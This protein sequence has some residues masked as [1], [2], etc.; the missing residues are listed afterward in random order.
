MATRKFSTLRG[1]RMRVTALDGCGRPIEGPCV[2]VVSKGFI[3]VGFSAQT[4][5]GTAIQTTNAAGETCISDTPPSQFTGYSL[6][7][8]FCEVDPDIIAIMSGNEREFSAET[9]DAVGFSVNS[10]VSAA[11]S[12]FALELWTDVPAQQCDPENP[13]AQ[14]SYG[15]IL[16]PFIQGGVFGDFTVQNDAITFTI[17]NANTKTGSGWGFGPYDVI[18]DNT[19]VAGPLQR[20]IRSGD[21]LRLMYTSIA[22]PEVTTTCQPNGIAPTT[23]TAGTPGAFTPSGAWTPYSLAELSTVTA[24]PLTAWTTGQRVVLGDGTSAHWTGTAW[25]AGAA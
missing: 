8:E 7:I 17:N 6:S 24:S 2:S 19:G 1:R 21:H 12:G 5:D 11:D 3:S 13:N 9:G 25:A 16:L 4:Q 23:A 18:E 22:P 20:V 10:D 15:Y 14:G